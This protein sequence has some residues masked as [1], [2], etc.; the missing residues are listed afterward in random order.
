MALGAI[1][2]SCPDG[3]FECR[4]SGRQEEEEEEPQPREAVICCSDHHSYDWG[5]ERVQQAPP[6]IRR[7]QRHMPC[8]PQQSP[9]RLEVP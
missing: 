5:P 4:R 6:A 2:P 7:Q 3:W 9:Q 8:A 1:D